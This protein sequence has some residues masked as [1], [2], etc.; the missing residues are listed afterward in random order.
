MQPTKSLRQPPHVIQDHITGEQ[1]ATQAAPNGSQCNGSEQQP[2][3]A[4]AAAPQA[5]WGNI[6]AELRARRQ[7][8]M[9]A[10]DKKPLTATGALASPIDPSTWGDFEIISK[11][12]SERDLHIGYV[13]SADDPFTCIDMDVKDDT[14]QQVVDRFKVVVDEFDSY[15]ER[16][17]SGKGLHVWVKGA[18]G[19]GR[20][21]HLEVYSQE[22]FIISTGNV[23]QNKPI[24]NRQD[25]LNTLISE[26]NAEKESAQPLPDRPE[27]SNDDVILERASNAANGDKFKAHFYGDAISHSDHSGADMALLQML[28]HYTPNNEQLKRLFLKSS[29]GQREKAKRKDYVP[30]TIEK[31]RSIQAFEHS[32]IQHGKLL[33]EQILLNFEKKQADKAAKERTRAESLIKVYSPDEYSKRPPVHWRIQGVLPEQGF[34]A[35]FGAPGS[36]KSFLVLDMLAHIASGNSWFGRRTQQCPVAYMAFESIGGIPQRWQAFEKE[37]WSTNEICFLEAPT[38]D[39]LEPSHREAMI[40]KLKEIWSR[41]GVLC[42]DTLAACAPGIDENSSEGMGKLIAELQAVQ[43]TVGGCIIVVHHSGKDKER[44]LRGWS[45]LNGALDASIEVTRQPTHRQ[46]QVVKAKDGK[47]GDSSKF[48]LKSVLISH[49]EFGSPISSCVISPASLHTNNED[50]TTL[51][52]KLIKELYEEGEYISP[53]SNAGNSAWKSLA[54]HPKL[55]KFINKK[56]MSSLLQQAEHEGL[57]VQEVYKNAHRKDSVRWNLK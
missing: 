34:A 54:D 50:L 37:H 17:R 48:E 47:D 5:N 44:G 45:G 19:K 7:W 31:V 53:K 30:I 13:L 14:D 3:V 21:D 12:A 40:D 9:A 24:E 56:T 18:I 27:V 42:I 52:L 6:P 16:S 49:D 2:N 20:R 39:L 32:R 26:I 28:A 51:L 35:I 8:C 46:W 23:V 15:T 4:P 25:L 55:P 41:N 1:N 33:A 29:L 57:L 10:P 38:L 11:A 22:R 36:G 43:A